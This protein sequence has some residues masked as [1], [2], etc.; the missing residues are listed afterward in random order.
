VTKVMLI[1][2]RRHPVWRSPT[3]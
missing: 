2:S 1:F 3:E